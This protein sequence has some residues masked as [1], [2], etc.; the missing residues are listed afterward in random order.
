MI[1]MVVGKLSLRYPCNDA[2]PHA[3]L[4]RRTP[5]VPASGAPPRQQTNHFPRHR[6]PP[7]P[8]PQP[9]WRHPLP[10][11]GPA[12][13]RR[14]EPGRPPWTAGGRRRAGPL[15]SPPPPRTFSAAA[16]LRTSASGTTPSLSP[17]R[18]YTGRHGTSPASFPGASSSSQRALASAMRRRA[19]RIRRRGHRATAAGRG[20]RWRPGAPPPATFRLASTAGATS[21][22]PATAVGAARAAVQREPGADRAA[23]Q[24]RPSPASRLRSASATSAASR[25]SRSGRGRRHTLRGRGLCSGPRRR[26]PAP[27]WQRVPGPRPSALARCSAALPAARRAGAGAA[28]WG[29]ELG[30][31]VG[32]PGAASAAQFLLGSEPLPGK[33]S[34]ADCGAAG[35]WGVEL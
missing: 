15:G 14:C 6:S 9:P 10:P 32:K 12:A 33:Y 13:Q 4:I 23:H 8:A 27:G 29:N 17:C 7:P 34:T 3:W 22:R 16:S 19:T 24:E 25:P 18:I 11:S 20:P 31:W 21:S 30:S 35:P 2:H 26:S 5:P 1:F 28:G